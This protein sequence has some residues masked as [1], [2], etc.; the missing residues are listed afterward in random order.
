MLQTY[1]PDINFLKEN[2]FEVINLHFKI[3]SEVLFGRCFGDREFIPT[4][5]NLQLNEQEL[6]FKKV[7]YENT[8]GNILL[9]YA[10]ENNLLTLTAY[11]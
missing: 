11:L 8:G 9:T 10:S 1:V 3:K 2:S 7:N 6:T 4:S 5:F